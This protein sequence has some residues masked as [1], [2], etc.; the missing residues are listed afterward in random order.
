MSDACYVGPA[1]LGSE[2][3]EY[4]LQELQLAADGFGGPLA[5]RLLTCRIEPPFAYVRP[6]LALAVGNL[7]HGGVG[8]GLSDRR[9]ARAVSQWISQPDSGHRR[10]LLLEEPL[11]RY[12]DPVHAT[13]SIHFLDRVYYAAS[14]R[15]TAEDVAQVCAELSGYPGVGVLSRP[16]NEGTYSG[17]LSTRELDAVARAAVA[18]LVRAWDNEAFLVA[19]VV[20][21]LA[22]PDLRPGTPVE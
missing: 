3:L 19:P 18:V 12:S 2:A 16:T 20:G 9:F 13:A 8:G 21:E 17:E 4:V 7:R 15:A 1:M 10:M 5:A 6:D 22:V 14:G 11:G